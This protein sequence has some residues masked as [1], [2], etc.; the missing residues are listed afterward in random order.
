MQI[1]LSDS[2][3][4]TSIT[5]K[6]VFSRTAVLEDFVTSYRSRLASNSIR[7]E[8]LNGKAK[9]GI[10]GGGKELPQVA[11]ARVFRKGDYYSGYYRD[12][13]FAMRTGVATVEK[14]FAALYGD[15]ENDIYSG[16]RQMNNHF[17]TAFN[18]ADGNWLK[19]AD[20]YNL[21]SGL[22]PLGGNITHALGLALATKM[23]K[24]NPN[25][26]DRELFS[27]NGTEVSICTVGDATT[28]EGV[29]FEA[30]NAAC[31]MKIP[32]V[33]VIFDDG[34]GISVPT[35]Y[36]TTKESISEVLEGFRINE[37]GEGAYLYTAKGWN[38]EELCRCFEEGI[39]K[40]RETHNPAVF[41]I[42]E[43]TQP[44]G[45][46]TSGSHER[47]KSPE[48]LQWEKD[49]DGIELFQ[50]WIIEQKFA[51]AEEMTQLRTEI[52]K[53]VKI[54]I[55]TAWNNFSH[56]IKQEIKTVRGIYEDIKRNIADDLVWQVIKDLETAYNPALA[57]VVKNVEQLLM[58]TKGTDLASLR[59]LD[60]WHERVSSK[61]K[62]TICYQSI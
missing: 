57:D 20:M 49:A 53:E 51:T 42:Q 18:D 37:K 11:I 4:P 26:K 52:E 47:Y 32:F 62:K 10:E 6:T 22:A 28:S 14:L 24:E 59:Q 35:K 60:S 15:A 16:G 1:A 8:T 36:Q 48:R 55:R 19:Q 29:F 5:Q 17:T 25:L 61:L 39:A 38:Y 34:H 2:Q 30:L 21:A 13:T 7:R 58:L 9:F 41:H 46:S 23:Y 31:V 33:Y 54:S 44:N 3:P 43:C 40:V 27:S 50:K 12:Q 56:P 45:H